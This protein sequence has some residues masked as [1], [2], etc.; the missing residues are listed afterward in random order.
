MFSTPIGHE[1]SCLK[2]L[3]Q[4]LVRTN[5]NRE[6]NTA[7]A[8]RPSKTPRPGDTMALRSAIP[9]NWDESIMAHQPRGQSG[10]SP[11]AAI[12]RSISRYWYRGNPFSAPF[13]RCLLEAQ[14]SKTHACTSAWT[15]I[16][17][18]DGPMPELRKWKPS[19]VTLRPPRAWAGE[20][21]AGVSHV[22]LHPH[23]PT[24][25]P[26]TAFACPRVRPRTKAAFASSIAKA[27]YLLLVPWDRGLL[28]HAFPPRWPTSLLVS[29]GNDCSTR[30]CQLHGETGVA[31]VRCRPLK[32]GHG[33]PVSGPDPPAIFGRVLSV[34]SVPK[35]VSGPSTFLGIDDPLAMNF[36]LG[37]TWPQLPCRSNVL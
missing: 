12:L 3:P 11:V 13:K 9:K 32:P 19:A 8:R 30:T 18:G 22:L 5:L 21:V 34:K 23:L 1:G 31:P 26:A 2:P 35:I 29:N 33:C 4:P 15:L 27:S 10:P 28:N 25:A 16:T 36:H 20:S 14:T 6:R 37:A 24:K 7:G 17:Y